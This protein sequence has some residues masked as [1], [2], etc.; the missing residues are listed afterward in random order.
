MD[1]PRLSRTVQR[2]TILSRDD[3]GNIVPVVV[4]DKGRK[5]KRGSRAL[6]PIERV[7]RRLAEATTSAT[8]KYL[9]AHKKANRKRRNGWVRDMNLNVVQAA[10][11]GLKKV[12]PG[13]LFNV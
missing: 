3:A 9:R 11:R 10:R 8:A 7:A 4:F 1:L 12:E 2:V 5:K 13:R 6:K